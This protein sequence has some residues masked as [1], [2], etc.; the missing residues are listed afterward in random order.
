MPERIVTCHACAT[1]RRFDD[2]VPRRADCERCGAA[3][4]ACR[5]CSLYDPSAYNDCREPS[6]E[7]VVDKQAANFCDFFVPAR[8]AEAARASA[9]GD[10]HHGPARDPHDALERLF[11]K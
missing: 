8:S 3:L 1:M 7:R 2:V 6:A 4:H 10:E 11:K 5:N 9:P